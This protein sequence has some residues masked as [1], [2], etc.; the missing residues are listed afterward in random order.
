MKN[1][2]KRGG[3]VISGKKSK[4]P[5]FKKLSWCSEDSIIKEKEKENYENEHN[6]EE[7]NDINDVKK[8]N[9]IY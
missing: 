3:S 5:I 2:V 9:Y 4:A 7:D 6:D 8:R 1:Q